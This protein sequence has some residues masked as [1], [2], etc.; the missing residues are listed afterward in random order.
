MKTI[1]LYAVQK[2]QDQTEGRGPMT[3]VYYAPT[4]ELAL[5]IVNSPI[6]Y[7]KSI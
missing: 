3:D 2:N 5:K 6:F 7:G 4:K 1:K